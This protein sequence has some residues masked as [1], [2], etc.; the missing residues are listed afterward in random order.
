M[1]RKSFILNSAT[2]AA[3]YP[4]LNVLNAC[5]VKKKESG[6]KVF[7]FIQLAGGNDGLHTLIPLDNYKKLYESRS[8]IYIPEN[9]ILS[10]K[11]TTDCG[12]H[13]SLVGIKDM[14]DNGLAGFVQGVGYENPNFSH[15]RSSDIWLT[16]SESSKVLYTGWVARYLETKFKNYPEGFPNQN[17]PHPPAIK[18]GDTGTFLFQGKAMDMSIVINPSVPFGESGTDDAKN[19][20][21]SFGMDEVK[22]IREMLLQTDKYAAVVKKALE[23]PFTS[24]KLYPEQGENP[25]ADQLKVVAK[26]INADMDT[27]VYLVDLKGFD[28]HVEQ[29]SQ[30][31]TTK[32]N[33]ADL[34]K[35]LSQA[36]TCFW[37]D[38]VHMGRENDVAGMTFSEFGRR[39]V[40][41][42]GYGSDHGSSQ[43]VLFF[44]SNI[45]NQLIGHN[46]VFPDKITVDDN[47]PLQYDFKSVY[48]SIMKQWYNVPEAVINEVLPG[49]FQ[50]L[51]MFNS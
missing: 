9:K 4:L 6:K 20:S 33:H 27:S 34:L 35:K 46:P 31:D 28:T 21:T 5:N 16:G 10:I 39:I 44:G 47:L 30:S 41:T 26:L 14:F 29:V 22:T 45:N 23:T 32:G 42:S 40:S 8:N 49:N 1:N 2:I 17:Y 43:P 13:P 15:F 48:T 24:S 36:I 18:I 50:K 12:L 37:E 7:V 3:M 19:E 11:G 25:L 38:I 51:N